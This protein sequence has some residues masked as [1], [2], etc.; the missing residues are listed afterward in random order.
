MG[1]ALSSA[2][3]S[4]VPKAIGSVRQVRPNILFIMAD[5]LG[6]ADL[7]C[8]GRREY[9][10]PAVDQLA[11]QGVRLTN[12]YANSPVCS[13]TRIALITGRY[14]YR[15][16][17]GLE[18]PLAP[19]STFGLPRDHPTL[20][21]ILRSGGYHTSLVG[22]WH[23]GDLPNYG[24]LQT[25]YD[26]FWGIRGGGVDY[27]SHSI[28]GKADLWDNDHPVEKAGYLTDLLGQ[29][30]VE[31][32]ERQRPGGDPFFL[33]LHFT[34]P[35]WPWEGPGDT[36]TSNRLA[37]D[38][39]LLALAQFDNGDMA[40]YAAMV[41][42]MDH[43]IGRVLNAL[44]RKGLA[45]N[46]IVVFTSDN[47]GERFSDVWPFT[48]RKGELL[49]GGIR[50]P[51]IVRWPAKIGTG[52]TSDQVAMSMDWLPTLL[53][54]AGVPLPATEITDGIDIMP[55]LR[56]PGL[57]TDRDVY[58]RFLNLG[59]QAYRSGR[60]KYLKILDNSFLFDVVSDPLE[61][62]NLKDRRPEDFA[63]MSAGYQAWERT[64]LPLDPKAFTHG[65]SG[66]ELADHFGVPRSGAP[67]P[68]PQ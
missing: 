51:A 28:I 45:G 49:E 22:K 10:T 25:G 67:I 52:T 40:T 55:S 14:Q 18:E 54:A 38:K 12:A 19:G 11:A 53:G 42:R 3:I 57:A 4:M 43:Q 44:E 56:T 36:E 48:G 64:M 41:T 27:F 2:A 8:Y 23:M 46:T 16:R 63:R 26:D 33:S 15:L 24:P 39:R 21:A 30:A 47:G 58:W 34:A 6:Y 31:V 1:G 5:D 60:L 50:V 66:G 35:H 37:S 61:R 17:A 65:F 9:R 29:R 7:S 20:P 13:A 62:A 59:Q 32:I 68:N